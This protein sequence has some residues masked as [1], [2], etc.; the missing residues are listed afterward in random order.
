LKT[1]AREERRRFSDILVKIYLIKVVQTN[2]DNSNK[3]IVRKTRVATQTS[4]Y[5][6]LK[7]E[8][9]RSQI[10]PKKD[11]FFEQKES[12]QVAKGIWH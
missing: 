11:S 3:F 4:L 8:C 2:M 12:Y 6:R 9:I 1:A 7:R 5:K 10:C